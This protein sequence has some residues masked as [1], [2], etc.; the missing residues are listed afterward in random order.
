MSRVGNSSTAATAANKGEVEMSTGYIKSVEHGNGPYYL[1]RV[2]DGTEEK[3]YVA[4]Y[5]DVTPDTLKIGDKIE[6]TQIGWDDWRNR[7][8]IAISRTVKM[9]TVFRVMTESG[10]TVEEIEAE[11]APEAVAEFL[12]CPIDQVSGGSYKVHPD[13]IHITVRNEDVIRAANP[14]NEVVAECNEILDEALADAEAKGYTKTRSR[15]MSQ[16]TEIKG[17]EAGWQKT[18]DRIKEDG[19]R[20]R[21]YCHAEPTRTIDGY[22][23]YYRIQIWKKGQEKAW[24]SSKMAM[25]YFPNAEVWSKYQSLLA[26]HFPE[27]FHRLL[28]ELEAKDE[29]DHPAVAKEQAEKAAKAGKHEE[30]AKLYR[31]ASNLSMGSESQVLNSRLARE[32]DKLAKAKKE[33]HVICDG[34][35]ACGQSDCVHYKYHKRNSSCLRECPYFGHQVKCIDARVDG[36]CNACSARGDDDCDTCPE[37]DP[38]WSA[39]PVAKLPEKRLNLDKLRNGKARSNVPLCDSILGLLNKVKPYGLTESQVNLLKVAE[40]ALR[41][42]HE[43]EERRNKPCQMCGSE[44]RVKD[45]GGE[46]RCTECGKLQ[47]D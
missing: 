26:K 24:S 36:D 39:V 4:A 35:L 27:D 20:V 38:D 29:I 1:M 16:K 28:T 14:F 31:L 22:S 19:T 17:I 6:F 47:W 5:E 21:L 41:R 2:S 32:Q 13:L 11:T 8:R 7:A 3:T 42:V 25:A 23:L 45:I 10:M 44:H 37:S 30:A 33:A 9:S 15:E 46:E 43:I 40:Y 18:H 12:D 34:S